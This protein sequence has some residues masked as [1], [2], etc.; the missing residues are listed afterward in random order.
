MSFTKTARSILQTTGHPKL[1]ITQFVN[2]FPH[3]EE[4]RSGAEGE[5]VAEPVADRVHVKIQRDLIHL[6]AR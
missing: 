6:G 4:T 3:A 1:N 2:A 5:E